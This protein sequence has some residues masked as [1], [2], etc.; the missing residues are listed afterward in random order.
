MG[1]ES[2]LIAD[3]LGPLAPEVFRLPWRVVVSAWSPERRRQ[4]A[5]LATTFEDAGLHWQAAERL[6]LVE[7]ILATAPQIPADDNHAF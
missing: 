3:V 2:N 1:E 5:E 6:A 4:W 7:V